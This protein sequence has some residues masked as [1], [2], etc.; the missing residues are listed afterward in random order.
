MEMETSAEPTDPL[1][2]SA[3]ALAVPPEG[4]CGVPG[5]PP[6]GRPSVVGQASTH[7]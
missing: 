1:T 5:A 7:T 3:A 4:G 2:P 6:A